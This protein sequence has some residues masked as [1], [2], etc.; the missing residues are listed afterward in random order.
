MADKCIKIKVNLKQ[1]LTITDQ[2][3]V[4]YGQVG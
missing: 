1:K 2:K 3:K 4:C